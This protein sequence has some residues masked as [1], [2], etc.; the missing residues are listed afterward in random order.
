MLQSNCCFTAIR[1]YNCMKCEKL[2][3]HQYF[4]HIIKADSDCHMQEY[5]SS[6][7]PYW[8]NRT[9]QGE[10]KH[11]ATE[12]SF[13]TVSG[14]TLCNSCVKS[15]AYCL[16]Y[17]F[18]L[19]VCM[20]VLSWV[21]SFYILK[22]HTHIYICTYKSFENYKEFSQYIFMFIA[23]LVRNLSCFLTWE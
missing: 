22:K 10:R 8:Y 6:H 18:M 14:D 5:Y 23:C 3:P 19:Y 2:D 15:C 4:V 7:A 1:Y 21:D 16:S 12:G 13:K 17:V 9:W 11:M 20:Y